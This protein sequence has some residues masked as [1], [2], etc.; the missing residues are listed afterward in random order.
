MNVFNVK[1]SA[2]FTSEPALALPR[3]IYGSGV[4]H[5]IRRYAP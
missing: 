4:V 1:S 2:D 3:S 5:L